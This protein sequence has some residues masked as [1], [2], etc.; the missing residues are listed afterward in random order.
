MMLDIVLD[1]FLQFH[2]AVEHAA[3]DT[4]VGKV[5]EEPFH[6]IAPRGTRRREVQ[7]KARMPGQPAPHRGSLVRRVVV[8]DQMDILVRRRLLMDQLEE[9][10]PIL[11]PVN[12]HFSST[13]TTSAPGGGCR[14][15]FTAS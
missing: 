8:Q 6:L 12:W 7:M 4:L 15:R 10:D 11:W 9:A 14:Y 2:H 5:A 1:R 3:P 13:E